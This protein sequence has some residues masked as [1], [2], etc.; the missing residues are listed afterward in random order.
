M[1]ES[2]KSSHIGQYPLDDIEIIK[3]VAK[4]FKYDVYTSI[5]DPNYTMAGRLIQASN[6]QLFVTIDASTVNLTEFWNEV[7]QRRN[8]D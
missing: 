2:T 4:Q 8:H 5:T 6:G 1:N 7:N 3:D